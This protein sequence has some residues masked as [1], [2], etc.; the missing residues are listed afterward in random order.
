[1]LEYGPFVGFYIGCG[2]GS[3]VWF[4][5]LCCWNPPAQLAAPPAPSCRCVQREDW[6]CEAGTQDIHSAAL[7]APDTVP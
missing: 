5:S 1:M 2:G 7:S 4:F 6:V 3:L